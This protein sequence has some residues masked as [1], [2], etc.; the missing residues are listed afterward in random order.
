MKVFVRGLYGYGTLGLIEI[1]DMIEN[2]MEW[3]GCEKIAYNF[4]LEFLD[5]F[6]FSPT[7]YSKLAKN[8]Q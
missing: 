8:D 4:V 3:I 5:V 2:N 6:R 7:H 1:S